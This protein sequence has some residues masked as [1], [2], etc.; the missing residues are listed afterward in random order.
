[1]EKKNNLETDKLDSEEQW[2]EDNTQGFKAVPGELR[3]KLIQAAQSTQL[4]T[5]RMNIRMTRS[6]MLRL[7]GLAER[8]GIPYQSLVSSVLHKYTEGLLVDINEARKLLRVK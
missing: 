5:E 4:K 2:F 1:M 3:E 6:D 7:K 8:E